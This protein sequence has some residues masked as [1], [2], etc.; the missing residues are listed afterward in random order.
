MCPMPRRARSRICCCKCKWSG[1]KVRCNA[2]IYRPSFRENKPKTWFFKF[3]H[4]T[5]VKHVWTFSLQLSVR[6]LP[7]HKIFRAR[8]RKRL[9][10]IDSKES[11]PSAYVAWRNLFLGIHSWAPKTFK[12]SGSVILDLGVGKF[13]LCTVQPCNMG[14]HVCTIYSSRRSK[15]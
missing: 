13:S 5:E 15:Q 12:N 2:R 6:I 14:M 11:V 8:I 3:G 4:G 1:L 10:S 7:H 9:R